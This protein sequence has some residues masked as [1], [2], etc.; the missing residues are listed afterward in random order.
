[1]EKIPF[2]EQVFAELAIFFT[3]TRVT[4]RRV[5]PMTA[6]RGCRSGD[7]L[8]FTSRLRGEIATFR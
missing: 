7:I 8:I 3:T 6:A 2:I 1:M 4:S 5:F